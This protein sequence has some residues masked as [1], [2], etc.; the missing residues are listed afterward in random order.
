[1]K[2]KATV[3]KKSVASKVTTPKLDKNSLYLSE[4]SYSEFH[5]WLTKHLLLNGLCCMSDVNVQI[6][7]MLGLTAKEYKAGFAKWSD[8]SLTNADYIFQMF[9]FIGRGHEGVTIRDQTKLTHIKRGVR[10]FFHKVALNNLRH[11]SIKQ[12]YREIIYIE[13]DYSKLLGYDKIPDHIFKAWSVVAKMYGYTASKK[14]TKV[15]FK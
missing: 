11:K 12:G 3:S 14:G 7:T 9:Y 5:K 2:N 8:R 10:K 4:L 6:R 15:Y 1:M 13:A